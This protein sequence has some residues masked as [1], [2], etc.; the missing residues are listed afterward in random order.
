MRDQNMTE[1]IDI[2]DYENEYAQWNIQYLNF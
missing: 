2:R 1:Y